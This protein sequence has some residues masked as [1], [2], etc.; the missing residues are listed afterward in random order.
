M[1]VYALDEKIQIV[2]WFYSGN[3]LR[4]VRDLF[5]ARF[6]NRPVPSV[7]TIRRIVTNFESKGCLSYANHKRTRRPVN[8]DLELRVCATVELDPCLSSRQIADEVHLHHTTVLKILKKHEYRSFKTSKS[9]TIYPNDQIKRMLF[10]ERLI[11]LSN[12]DPNFI[13]NIIFTDE[14]TFPINGRH[15]PSIIRC[16]SRNNPHRYYN[17]RTQYP[18]KLNT[19]M[20]I[21]G[22]HI[23]GPFFIDG[24]LNGV[25]YLALLRNH[26]IPSLQQ[27]QDITLQDLWY[28]QD[29]CPAHNTLV[30]REYL[31]TIFR[32][33]IIGTHGDIQWPP[34]SPDLS[35]QDFFLW[36]Y[37][38]S[39]IYG[40]EEN[41]ANTL[42]D[43]RIKIQNASDTIT[44]EMFANVR[45]GFYNRLGYCLTEAGSLFEYLL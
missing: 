19:W 39:T 41:R 21:V 23:L 18:R 15:N 44:P 37:M 26:I 3:S 11:E 8:N 16:W 4:V 12:N 34:R 20:G 7:T 10:C 30:V 6:E 28:Q 17:Y 9:H 22:D 24:N 31:Q 35:P 27:I 45:N 32:N 42:D 13:K 29:G 33:R 25:K 40:F 1:E 36:G 14:S 5:N 38:K 2:K 43:L